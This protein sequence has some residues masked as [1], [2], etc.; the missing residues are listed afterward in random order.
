MTFQ[1]RF[2]PPEVLWQGRIC[3]LLTL[4][5]YRGI[6]VQLSTVARSHKSLA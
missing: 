3:V 6:W 5:P 1:T 4:P 2:V